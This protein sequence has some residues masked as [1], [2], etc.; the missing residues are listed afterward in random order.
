MFFYSSP[1]CVPWVHFIYHSSSETVPLASSYTP[2]LTYCSYTSVPSTIIQGFALLKCTVET[3][4]GPFRAGDTW[5][6]RVLDPWMNGC[7]P[8]WCS[9]IFIEQLHRVYLDFESIPDE[10]IIWAEQ[11]LYNSHKTLTKFPYNNNSTVIFYQ[12]KC[13]LLYL[14]RFT[15]MPVI[16][17]SFHSGSLQ[18]NMTCR[19][20][21]WEPGWS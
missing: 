3:R 7:P 17:I 9:Y 4:E 15:C 21:Q 13:P 8:S 20:V 19:P 12:F 16:N 11:L 14:H 5:R 10:A 2:A 18:P 6:S 1:S